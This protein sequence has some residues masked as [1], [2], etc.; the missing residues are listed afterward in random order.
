MQEEDTVPG[1]TETVP[2]MAFYDS[3]NQVSLDMTALEGTTGK[4][5]AEDTSQPPTGSHT[6]TSFQP[7]AHELLATTGLPSTTATSVVSTLFRARDVLPATRGLNVHG[8]IDSLR[9]YF[10]V[11]TEE[12]RQR[13]AWSFHPRRGSMLLKQYDLYA[14]LM[15]T[16]TLAAVLVLGMKAAHASSRLSHESTLIGTAL[17]AAFTLW[18]LPTLGVYVASNLLPNVPARSRRLVPIG[19]ATGY[20]LAGV[21]APLALRL[22]L[23][24]SAACWLATFSVGVASSATLVGTVI[25]LLAGE[26]DDGDEQWS[27]STLD[28]VASNR[29]AALMVGLMAGGL[30]VA[31]T[32]FLE[33]R[34]LEE[35]ATASAA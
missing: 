3:S 2:A 19:C 4:M 35:A 12:V 26:G 10:D 27:G 30:N 23:A 13:I 16:F 11:E 21:L 31:G 8:W 6:N 17:A 24:S 5:G 1:V 22:L 33:W 9:P 15:L 29:N 7:L 32:L 28:G 25:A 18:L 14:P 20:S 34:Y